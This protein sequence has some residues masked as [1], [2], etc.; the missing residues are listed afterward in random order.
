MFGLNACYG[1]GEKRYSLALTELVHQP[2][3]LLCC[4][5]S[6]SFCIVCLS[7]MMLDQSG[8]PCAIAIANIQSAG[9]VHQIK[10]IVVYKDNAAWS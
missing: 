6:Y 3:I 4:H 5:S 7:W 10:P 8:N 1:P 9:Q 2:S